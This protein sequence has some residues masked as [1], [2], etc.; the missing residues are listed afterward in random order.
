[1]LDAWNQRFGG[2]VRLYGVA[3]AE[4]IR[5][6]RVAIVG[7]GGV[8]SWTAEALARTGVAGLDLIDLDD[9]CISNANRQLHALDGEV[10]RPKVTVMAERIQRIHPGC[11]VRAIAEFFTAET[12]DALLDAPYDVVVDAIDSPRHK[13]LLLARCHARGQAVVTVGAAGGRRDPSQIATADLS[14]ATHDGLLRR[15]RRRLRDEHGFAREGL[16]GIDAVYSREAAWYPTP[17]GEVCL[18]GPKDAALRLDCQSGYGTASFTTGAFGLA[19]AS[20]AIA[21]VVRSPR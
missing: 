8:G 13:C 19:A 20:L 9:V 21:H 7:V 11:E 15:V 4:R 1:M 12:A 5:R 17:D 2:I 16:F 6:A 10:G 14:L 3:A 18:E